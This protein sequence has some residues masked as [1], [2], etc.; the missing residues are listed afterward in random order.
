[1]LPGF[2][3]LPVDAESEQVPDGHQRA[4]WVASGA[5]QQD[6]RLPDARLLFLEWA[7]A[8]WPFTEDEKAE[9]GADAIK[10]V[11]AELYCERMEIR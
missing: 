9:A 6:A 8:L 10:R 7:A 2:A 5:A 1:M 11:V 3:E 4:G